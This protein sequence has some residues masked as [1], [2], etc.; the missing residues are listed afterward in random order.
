MYTAS[1]ILFSLNFRLD[2]PDGG[3]P[4]GGRR[5]SLPRIPVYNP[6]QSPVVQATGNYDPSEEQSEVFSN[7]SEFSPISPWQVN[8]QQEHSH[9]NFEQAAQP[10]PVIMDQFDEFLYKSKHIG[11]SNG[12]LNS[13]Q[14]GTT[15]SNR[16][17]NNHPERG[18]SNNII[19]V[20]GQILKKRTVKLFDW[21]LK[22]LS[23]A[24]YFTQ[25]F[26][27]RCS[28]GPNRSSIRFRFVKTS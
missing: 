12:M 24:L 6:D 22:T 18:S 14:V 2:T 28:R 15:A 21:T 23:L 8:R 4:P 17:V 26:S 19:P 27:V 25:F 10:P 7:N 16:K 11:S 1:N 13:Q 5:R 3:G 20:R 9:F